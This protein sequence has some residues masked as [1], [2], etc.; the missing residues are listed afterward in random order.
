MRGVPL[1]VWPH[2][3]AHYFTCIHNLTVCLR[4]LIVD[5]FIPPE[6]VEQVKGR[7]SLDETTDE[8]SL[9]ASDIRYDQTLD[10]SQSVCEVC[11]CGSTGRVLVS[12]D[13]S[14]E[15]GV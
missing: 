2:S 5:N 9:R 7:A 14:H 15:L 1:I 11:R 4:K 12:P 10:L 3:H 8:W 13:Q 6:V